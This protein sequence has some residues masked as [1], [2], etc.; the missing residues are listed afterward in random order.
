[1]PLESDLAYLREEI[2]PAL[3]ELLLHD[4][5]EQ[6]RELR[7]EHEMHTGPGNAE[8]QITQAVKGGHVAETRLRPAERRY[9]KRNGS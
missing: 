3:L 5:A 8:I 6:L 7:R 2:G 4:W 9:A 1:M